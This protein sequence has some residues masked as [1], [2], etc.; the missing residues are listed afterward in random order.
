MIVATNLWHK[1]I[2]L[3]HKHT[4]N[5]EVMSKNN[6]PQDLWSSDNPA[7][8]TQEASVL[9]ITPMSITISERIY[10]DLSSEKKS[11]C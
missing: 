10:L 4:R 7:E 8:T 11:G 3:W 6:Q 1:Y 9:A 2:G 5:A